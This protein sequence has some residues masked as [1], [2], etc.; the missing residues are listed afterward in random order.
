MPA[1]ERQPQA[2][3]G[4]G[5][6]DLQPSR[7]AGWTTERIRKDA[8]LTG[9]AAAAPFELILDERAHP[10]KGF[11]ACLGIIWLARSYGATAARRCGYALLT[12]PSLDQL[13]A[14]GLDGMAKAFAD[15]EA[16]GEAASLDHAEWFALLPEREASLRRDKRPSKRLQYAKLCQQAC[17]EDIDYRTPRGLDSAC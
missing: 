9:P 13:H 17:T 5:A 14:L 4:A 16:G 10:E 6:H 1:H 11:R 8:H 3:G 2:H 7:Y 15:I 12:H